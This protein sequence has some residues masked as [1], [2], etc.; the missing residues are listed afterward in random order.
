MIKRIITSTALVLCTAFIAFPQ[1][2][3]TTFTSG[4][5]KY[6]I[7]SATNKEVSVTG[8]DGTPSGTLTIPKTVTYSNVSYKL[9]GIE[10]TAFTTSNMANVKSL[11]INMQNIPANVF[12]NFTFMT[13]EIG[14]DV[15]TIN[16]NSFNNNNI[17]KTIWLCNDV[18]S[19]SPLC[20]KGKINYCSSTNYEG[21][22]VFSSYYASSFHKYATLRSKFVV[23]GVTY[24]YYNTD[25][26]VIDCDYS[27][28]NISVNIGS[29]V[30][31]QNQTFNVRNIN[32]YAC[33]RDDR[34]TGSIILANNG[35]VGLSA[36]ESCSNATGSITVSSQGD[37]KDNA[38]KNCSKVA[39]TIT[40]TNSGNI[41]DNA[42][43]SCSKATAGN[44]QNQGYIGQQAFISCSALKTLQ[45]SNSGYIGAKAFNSCTGLE[46]LEV[47]NGGEIKREA[48]KGCGITNSATISNNG[49]IQEQ[50]F[51]S[52]TGSFAATINNNGNLADSAFYQ[53]QMKS[54]TINS[55]VKNLGKRCF[56]K[57]T[58]SSFATIANAGNVDEYAFSNISG[59]FDAD[60][61]VTGALPAYCFSSSTM[62]NVTIGN[63]VT[64]LGNYCFS[65]AKGFTTI[66]LPSNVITL[67]TYCFQNCT[68]MKNIT[69][70]RGLTEIP[71]GTFNGCSSL[72][73]LDIWKEI[74]NIG[75]YSFNNCSNLKNLIFE[76][77]DNNYTYTLG[78]GGTSSSKTSLF[79]TCGLDSVY[80]GGK[81]SYD[82]NSP[83]YSPF[84]GNTSLRAI[85]FAD[86]RED[87]I[88]AHE[89]ENCT[90]LQNVWMNNVMSSIGAYA[91]SGC[92]S[93]KKFNV[94]PAVNSLGSYSFKGCSVLTDINLSN[95][96]TIN[97]NSF[98]SCS[99]L[100]QI[101]I[102]Q[103]TTSIGN[104]TFLSCTSLK[105]L[106]IEDRPA[107]SSLS[108]G[109]NQANVNY[110]GVTGAGKPLF[111][112]CP[113]DSVY[114]GGP[115]TYDK[116]L[117][118][119]YSP[120][121][122][123]ES[124]R[125]VY[126][127]N[128]EKYVYEYEFHR[129]SGLTTVKLGNGVRYIKE[130]AFQNCSGLTYFEFAST[131]QS[132]GAEAFSDCDN[133][134]TL[135][136]HAI[137]PPAVGNQG[138]DDI[139]KF[140]CTLYVPEGSISEYQEADQW[141]DFFNMY[142][143][144]PVSGI[145]IQPANLLLNAVGE[146]ATLAVVVTPENAMNSSVTWTSSNPDVA[147]VSN[148]GVVTAVAN[149]TATI[150]ATTCDGTN[151]TASCNVTV[152]IIPPIEFADANVKALC[153]ANWDTNGDG[154]LSEAEAAAVTDLGEVFKNDTTI[155]SFNE[156]QYFTGLTEISANAFYLCKY[157]NTVIIPENVT[158]IGS[159][160]F[161][162][163][164][165]LA[166]ITIPES[167]T[168]IPYAAFQRCL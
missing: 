122:F 79:K 38:F 44:I 3:N 32:N 134:T 47:S 83:S 41:G 113:L 93:L 130:Y 31:Y 89:F 106:F 58:I 61:R 115:I 19:G 105:R 13:L 127:T 97:N 85:L 167:I 108:L 70:S 27:A 60:I 111:S 35:Y 117:A 17:Y 1:S 11:S 114:I 18:P 74:N 7:T 40:V 57:S 159:S 92:T 154:E 10:S 152:T 36:F 84:M 77:K 125:S 138:L 12:K 21:S 155:T 103:S 98:Q 34:I 14:S 59:G 81:L 30:T 119:G 50:A 51:A 16:N 20:A 112:D 15:V 132:I 163:C 99:S 24:V 42:F 133:L 82:T 162:Y 141:R 2:V 76:N 145:A 54:L 91:F 71:E 28:S 45:V 5:L 33:Y 102:P 75:N 136:S 131:L 126:I 143:I 69:L 165:R 151:L 22:S 4:G 124:L 63:A 101:S 29:T 147:T 49:H 62:N 129:C 64:S 121:Y 142:E 156:L 23:N 160:A 157:L 25:C 166:S 118:S 153:V 110:N 73:R 72:L 120:F 43:A 66:T 67:G 140:N 68:T 26:D 53:S 80:V 78:Y 148:T 52:V 107:N 86:D 116:S 95:V 123:N 8:P 65:G 104:Q 109:I 94:G 149:G 150:T 100:P 164:P 90:K 9:T 128:Q 48:F 161:M 56:H 96:V 139:N 146:T 168:S 87:K 137:T 88:S 55:T 135:I 6:K 46:T 37:I 144:I 158:V 39:G